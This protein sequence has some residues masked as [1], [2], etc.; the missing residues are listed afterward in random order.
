MEV[1]I[2]TQKNLLNID[3]I[4]DYM[5]EKSYWAKERTIQQTKKTVENSFCFGMYTDAK[6]QIGFARIVTD[7]VFFGNIMDVIIDPE[8]QGKGLG[9]K[10][11]E[12]MLQHDAI[13]SLQTITLKTKDAHSF[14]EKYGFQ[15]VGNSQ[16]YM[17]KDK[18]I[19]K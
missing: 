14:Y 5:T 4:H 7:F 17:S 8:Y 1:T 11:V 2:S 13:K 10:L 19:L 18:Q 9:K 15:R 6:Q 3:F 16:L 12:F